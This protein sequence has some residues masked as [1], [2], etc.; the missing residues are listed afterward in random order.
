MFDESMVF[1][2]IVTM[3]LAFIIAVALS[4]MKGD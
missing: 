2:V 1:T 4:V 3:L